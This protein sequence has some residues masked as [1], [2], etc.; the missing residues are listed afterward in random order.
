MEHLSVRLLESWYSGTCTSCTSLSDGFYFLLVKCAFKSIVDH[1]WPGT[2]A[3]LKYERFHGHQA[4]L[5]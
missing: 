4:K 1:T 3:S 5:K 2:S